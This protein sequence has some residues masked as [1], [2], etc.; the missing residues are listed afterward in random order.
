MVE[1]AVSPEHGIVAGFASGGECRGDVIDRGE[2]RVVVVL[3]AR[4]AG[5]AGQ[6]VV[7][8]HMAVRTLPWRRSMGTGQGKPGAVVVK[9]RVQPRSRVVALI[10][11]LGKIRCHVT[12]IRRSLVVLQV[13]RYAG[14]GVESVIVIDVAIGTLPRGNRVHS[15][16]GKGCRIV[17]ERCIRPG[18]G[19]MTL[20]ARLRES[21]SDVIWVGGPLVVLQMAGH[22]RGAGEVVVVV[23]VAVGANARRNGVA[24]C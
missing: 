3:V 16:Q 8:V 15:G 7:V 6:V 10:A 14:R 11:V 21:G 9:G 4:H 12:R 1:G 2:R 19:V 20:L 5:R 23:D 17:V 24:A 13:A 18:S 22:A